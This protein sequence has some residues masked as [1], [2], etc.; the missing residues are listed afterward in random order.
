[1]REPPY[2][3]GLVFVE[4]YVVGVEASSL[5]KIDYSHKVVLSFLNLFLSKLL[6]QWS[7]HWIAQAAN[8]V[9]RPCPFWYKNWLTEFFFQYWDH[10]VPIVFISLYSK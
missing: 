1:M 8:I 10:I 6:Q 9:N 2:L 7:T 3:I 5:H 4:C